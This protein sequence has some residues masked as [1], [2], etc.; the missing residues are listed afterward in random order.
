[1]SELNEIQYWHT[2]R[3]PVPHDQYGCAVMLV[4]KLRCGAGVH[5]H[6]EDGC[7]EIEAIYTLK[8]EELRLRYA[9]PEIMDEISWLVYLSM[10]IEEWQEYTCADPEL[11]TGI[12]PE[13][14]WKATRE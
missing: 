3:E 11:P 7:I 10:T 8:P 5:Q 4:G 12:D 6:P 9:T 14:E 2:Y 1:M 13:L